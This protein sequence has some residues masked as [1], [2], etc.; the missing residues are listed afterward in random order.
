MRHGPRV[1]RSEERRHDD[2]VDALKELQRTLS[3]H[4]AG[5]QFHA[6]VRVVR[7]VIVVPEFDEATFGP[8]ILLALVGL[9]GL[10]LCTLALFQLIPFLC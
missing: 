4:V 7:H 1:A 6:R 3:P 2:G 10:L 5:R 9:G 8:R